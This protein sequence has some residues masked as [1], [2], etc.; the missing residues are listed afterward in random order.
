[1]QEI[2]VDKISKLLG[3]D[4]RYLVRLFKEKTG[5][6]IQDYII[7]VRMDEACRQLSLGRS[8]GEAANLCGYHD[9]CNFSKMFKKH[10]GVS[11]MNWKKLS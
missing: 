9:A 3:L 10:Y 5:Q 11:P 6:T 1:M 8:I 4:R 2:S 7:S